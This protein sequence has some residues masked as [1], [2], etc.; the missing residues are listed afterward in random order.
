MKKKIIFMLID[1]NIGGTEKAL[2]NMVSEFS[3]GEYDITILMLEEH[4]GFLSY[5]P[6]GINIEYL[7]GYSSMK[8]ALNQPPQ[9]TAIDY[10][11]EGELVK[12]FNIA[13]L[14][15]IS[16]ITKNR[17]VFF[18]YVLNNQPVLDG[19]YDVAVAYAGPMDFISYFVVNKIKAKKKVQWIHFDVTKIGF[20]QAFASKTYIKFDKIF[21][22]SEEAKNKL[23]NL[24]PALKERTKVFF[25]IVSSKMIHSQAKEGR[26]FPDEIDGLRIVTVG[27]LTNEK[28]QD[29]AIR[30][31]AR[32]IDNGYKVKWYCVGEGKSRIEY[33]K[34]VVES[35]LQDKFI[36]LGADPNPYPYIA[37]CDIY[38]QPSRYE[39]YC[40]TL[41]EARCLNRP[42]V[43]TDVNGAKEQ[44]RNGETGLIVG[45]NEHEI[46][47][48]VVQLIDNRDLCV[49][50]SENLAQE[51]FD[52]K[53]E[54]NKIYNLI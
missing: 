26:A 33:E 14:H 40:I 54:M 30:V 9:V 1:M 41:I 31:L 43:T 34:L 46:Y 44:I 11:K 7:K 23:I 12:S 4:G 36:F 2:L 15:L 38:V 32:L 6:A 25:N 48:A 53:V 8:Q 20:N 28:G 49:K 3:L 10:F 52:S 35:N 24:V 45:I 39:G 51:N 42:I 47:Q 17:S 21:V 50:F 5:I 37:E 13:L 16:K 22:V 19:E 18:K 27:R 29:L